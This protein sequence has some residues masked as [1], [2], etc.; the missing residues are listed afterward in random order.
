MILP[1]QIGM[2]AN[3]PQGDGTDASPYIIQSPAELLDLATRKYDKDL[4]KHYV[5]AENI[6]LS[7]TRWTPIGDETVP[8]S[9][10]FDGNGHSIT[11]LSI[12]GG[13]SKII[14]LFGYNNG[15]IKKLQV[16]GTVSGTDS[17]G[18]LAGFNTG[19]I[20][21]CWVTGSVSGSGYSVGALV[22][23]SSGIITECA[24]GNA[25][26]ESNN[27][28]A[29]G[30]IGLMSSGRMEN[31][32]S[33]ANVNASGRSTFA[34]GLIGVLSGGNVRYTYAAG[35]LSTAAQNANGLIGRIDANGVVRDS[36]YDSD[37]TGCN[38]SSGTALSTFQSQSV[39]SYKGWDFYGIWDIYLSINNNYPF[40][41]NNPFLYETPVTDKVSSPT[42]NPG[43]GNVAYGTKVTLSSSTA[44]AVI[45]YTTNGK[46]PSESSTKYT[47]PITVTENMTIKAIAVSPGYTNSEIAEYAYKIA[48]TTRAGAPASNITSGT[49]SYGTIL[50]LT[51]DIRGAVIYYTADGKTPTASSKKY[52][53]PITLTSDVNIKAITVASGYADSNITDLSFKIRQNKTAAPVS[54]ISSGTVTWGTNISL[55]TSTNGAKIYFTINGSNPTV[56]SSQYTGPI[57]IT[58][59]TTIKAIAVSRDLPDSDIAT[60]TY[61]LKQS[62]LTPYSMTIS[63]QI[64]SKTYTKN[65]ETA[66]FDVAPYIEPSSNRTM[67]PIRFIA[68]AL[69]ATVYWD[70]PTSTDYITLYD[71]TLSIV[72]N[73]QLPNNMGSSMLI[74]DRLFVPIRYVSEQLGAKVDWDGATRTVIITK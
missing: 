17:T 70:N 25:N 68:E 62:D 54:N 60:F 58:Q 36:Y 74:N 71:K 65:G 12:S 59:N 56:S 18:I 48:A 2:A 63:L 43:A 73:K 21:Q 52:T 32:F 64:G 34:G 49:V 42:A 33:V 5:L 40:L 9:G 4:S 31:C 6:S 57:T 3:E 53:E 28:Y 8:F 19:E 14:G 10:V 67:V 72:L 47:Q 26:V 27:A 16:T 15:V 11:G 50:T 7:G 69:G 13:N 41:R 45:Y 38:D 55:S 46:A 29:G 20:S 66:Y 1:P 23:Q 39:S 61:T 44:G 37:A 35:R 30:L 51:S 22:G 24:S